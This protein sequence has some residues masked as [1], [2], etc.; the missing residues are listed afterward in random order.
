LLEFI[1]A[2]AV[3]LR[4]LAPVEDLR[5]VFEPERDCTLVWGG[6]RYPIDGPYCGGPV[7]ISPAGERV[8]LHPDLSD[9]LAVMDAAGEV[10]FQVL[11]HFL[12]SEGR[13]S[14]GDFTTDYRYIVVFDPDEL[15]VFRQE[16]ERQR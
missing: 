14:V 9:T 6:R 13:W 3:R 12:V 7:R 11:D 16:N 2:P 4:T 10:V 15:R 8:E 1:L 5:R